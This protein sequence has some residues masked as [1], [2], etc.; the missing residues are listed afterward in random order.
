MVKNNYYTLDNEIQKEVGQKLR[1]LLETCQAYQLPM[2]ATVAVSNAEEGT[3]YDRVVYGAASHA[4]VLTEDQIRHHILIADGFHAVPER[5]DI[6]LQ[7]T[8]KGE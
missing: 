2:F 3:R 4:M 6:V 1:S 5:E 7:L 8:R